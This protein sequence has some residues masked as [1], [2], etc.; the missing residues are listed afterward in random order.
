MKIYYFFFFSNEKVY[1]EGHGL[2]YWSTRGDDVYKLHTL[3]YVDGSSI[4]GDYIYKMRAHPTNENYLMLIS[5]DSL[6]FS[7]NYEYCFFKV[8]YSRFRRNL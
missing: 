3:G 4:N 6:C 8:K 1:F 2:A 7:T 5:W